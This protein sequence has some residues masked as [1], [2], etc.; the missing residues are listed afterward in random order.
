VP[1]PVPAPEAPAEPSYEAPAVA[2]EP[3]PEA[4][5]AANGISL[6]ISLDPALASRISRPTPL[7]II[8]RNPGGGA[9][10]AVIRANSAELPIS[11]RL[12]DANAMME[13]V[14][15]SDQPELE[16]I[17][18]VALSGSPAQNP[19]DLFGTVDYVRGNSG[20]TRIRIDR[21]AE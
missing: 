9:P 14:T 16:L 21:V 7:F 10:L 8:A 18:R 1:A 19:G 5:P 12:T 11:V 2:A 6:E 20:T 13:G 15:I 17:A 4:Q 3:A